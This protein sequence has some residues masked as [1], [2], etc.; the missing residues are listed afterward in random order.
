[1]P[2]TTS[3]TASTQHPTPNPMTDT[4]ETA[5]QRVEAGQKLFKQWCGNSYEWDALT[6]LE[7]ERWIRLAEFHAQ[8]K[9]ELERKLDDVS[10]GLQGMI[11]SL[12]AQ[13]SESQAAL[14]AEGKHRM[15]DQMLLNQVQDEHRIKVR[16][17][18]NEILSTQL[19]NRR[20]REALEGALPIVAK[21]CKH[22][23]GRVKMNEELVFRKIREALS[24][25]SYE[26][27]IERV[28]ERVTHFRNALMQVRDRQ[29]CNVGPEDLTQ[30]IAQH[31]ELLRDLKGAANE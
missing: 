24:A 30:A 28:I 10:A 7:Q 15:E 9:A 6:N 5:A 2:L 27:L 18:S 19:A 4:P 3:R 22:P 17:L 13:L 26:Q 8:E 14:E 25:P 23:N 29:N 16:D 12:K 20:L 11:N 1:M 31:D 21:V